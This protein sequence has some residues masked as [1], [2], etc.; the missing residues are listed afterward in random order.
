[1][2]D[3]IIYMPAGKTLGASPNIHDA[4]ML[5]NDYCKLSYTPKK[6]RSYITSKSFKWYSYYNI[7]NV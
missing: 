4:V 5:W 3:I 7:A 1:M 2:P 6:L